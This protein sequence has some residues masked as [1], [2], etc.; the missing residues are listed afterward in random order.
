[1]R[2]LNLF[3]DEQLLGLLSHLWRHFLS[4]IAKWYDDDRLFVPGHL[5]QFVTSFGIEVADPARAK[6]LLGGCQTKMLH[7]DGDVDVAVRLAILAHPLL[8]M[9]QGG[10][11]IQRGF[12][13]P[14][15]CV[16]GLKLCPTL[17][18][19]NDAEL[20]GLPVHSRRSKPHTL[21]E[22]RDFIILHRL[23]EVTTTAVAAPNNAEKTFQTTSL[24]LYSLSCRS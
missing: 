22:V 19:A 5:E 24:G 1:M 11:N 2:A 18:T 7:R 14:R 3:F 15:T 16:A 13:E 12:G 23:V 17:L 10:K 21:L 20:P 4:R 8:F 9:K 6:S